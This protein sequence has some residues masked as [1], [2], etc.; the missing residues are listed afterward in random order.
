MRPINRRNI[1]DEVKDSI[2][3][4]ALRY[5]QRGPRRLALLL[6][7][8][9]SVTTSSINGILHQKDLRSCTKRI[10][11]AK[12][13]AIKE[14]ET[15]SDESIIAEKI[16]RATEPSETKKSVVVWLNPH[17]RRQQGLFSPLLWGKWMVQL[18]LVIV[19]VYT[20]FY[21]AQHQRQAR[22]DIRETVARVPGGDDNRISAKTDPRPSSI[23]RIVYPDHPIRAIAKME[24]IDGVKV[25]P[26]SNNRRMSAEGWKLIGTMVAD[27]PDKSVAIIEYLTTRVQDTFKEGDHAGNLH[28][29][30][31]LRDR[32]IVATG[33]N[34]IM[35]SLMRTLPADD[36][37]DSGQSRAAL[38]FATA[39]RP[40][41]TGS[42]NSDRPINTR[43]P[44]GRNRSLHLDRQVV[45]I[46]LAD[47][48]QVLQQVAIEQAE[49][50]GHPSG[51]RIASIEA[52]SIF[53]D[54]G[55][56]STDVIV[57]VNGASITTPDQAA[58]LLQSIKA[59][60]NV[61]IQVRG[62]RRN[63]II[64]LDIS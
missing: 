16:D 26:Q 18:A 33:D 32:I 30:R 4:I 8:R 25:A 15:R 11:R 41:V 31:I 1:T 24:K 37:K 40:Q 53:A 58:L 48:D 28:I 7:D 47:P 54:L 55:L 35:I 45:E 2:V 23:V 27:P 56:Q 62:K 34:E 17:K 6:R 57:G 13:L 38:A 64:Q 19:A 63:R 61:T 20:G 59:G 22:R 52:G 9:I 43:R 21:T 49:S 44:K 10:E 5:P 3:A 51:F 60:G 14:A 29:N 42:D 46:S 39:E 12:A 50:N 36:W